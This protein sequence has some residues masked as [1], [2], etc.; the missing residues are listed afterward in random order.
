MK[1]AVSLLV[2]ACAAAQEPAEILGRIRHNVAAQVSRSANYSCVESIE[3]K[4]FVNPSADACA[5]AP[6]DASKPYLRDRL[7]LDVA[8]S[9]H[10]EIFSWHG[11]NNFTS[12]SVADVVRAGPI[13]SGGFIGYLMNIFLEPNIAIAY[14]GESDGAYNFRYEVS[15]ANSKYRTMTR[16]GYAH[17]P[18]HGSFS[19]D[20][21]SFQLKHLV[22][23]GDAFPGAS[24]ICFAESQVDYQIA[25]IA[26][27]DALIPT[28]YLLSVGNRASGLFTESRGMYSGC[29]EFKGESTLV[30]DASGEP[31]KTP[32]PGS[33]VTQKLGAGKILH[34]KLTTPIGD[35]T[36]FTGDRV[37]GVVE[38]PWQNAKVRGVIT[39]LMTRYQPTVH[40]YLKIEFER[41]SAGNQVYS[42]RALHKP[43]GHEAGKLYF[44]FG[45]NLPEDVKR[46]IQQGT[47]IF[48]AKHF[49]LKPGFTGDWQTINPPER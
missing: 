48:D 45:D 33:S 44:L 37:D 49:R 27:S 34:I 20:A 10:A 7:R 26:G 43:T 42:L 31:S 23:T 14:V 32:D 18:F 3:R 29:R 41:M 8:V 24:D 39:E 46:Q 40:Y 15:L 6:V 17:I 35:R 25:Q 22:V 19:A 38:G 11:E 2:C 16:E 9:Q 1:L 5:S 47:M 13:S 4:F 21:R 36:S 28:G 30:F 12:T